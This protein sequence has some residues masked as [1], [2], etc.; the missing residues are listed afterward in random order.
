MS[1]AADEQ[2]VGQERFGEVVSSLR[3]RLSKVEEE[4]AQLQNRVDEL[5]EENQRLEEKVINNSQHAGKE[6][7]K[8]GARIATLEDSN[9]DE[10]AGQLAEEKEHRGREVAKLRRHLAALE[11]EINVSVTDADLM[12]D[13]KITRVLRHGV[14]DVVDGKIWPVH[15][16]ARDILANIGEWGTRQNDANGARFY[17]TAAEAKSRLRD[18]RDE[19]LQSNEVRRAFEKIEEWGGDSPRHVL[20]SNSDGKN[21]LVISLE[22]SNA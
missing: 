11:D 9:I 6:R 8:L 20:A 19:S 13:D 1:G 18:K 22:E 2:T 12:G 5:E 14:S 21:R 17:I 15:N 16:R 7:A 3:R 4:N 10:L